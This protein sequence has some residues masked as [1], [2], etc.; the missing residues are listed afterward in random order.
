MLSSYCIVGSVET[1]VCAPLRINV[2]NSRVSYFVTRRALL[3]EL[4]KNLL[5][6][7]QGRCVV[8][9]G[10]GGIGKTQLALEF[11]LRAEEARKFMTIIW[12]NASTPVSVMQG[13]S[14]AAKK[15]SRGDHNSNEDEEI[16]SF[17][18][19]ILNNKNDP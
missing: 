9:I 6:N 8:M 15:L 19:A 11:C 14:I 5:H 18:K 13:Y 12:I 10:M 2:P 4:D 16:L 1:T 3:D 17:V 7:S